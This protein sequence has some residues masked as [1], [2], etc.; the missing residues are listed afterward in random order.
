VLQRLSVIGIFMILIYTPYRKNECPDVLKPLSKKI[1]GKFKGL[2]IA[3]VS[4]GSL[5]HV[6][7]PGHGK[8]GPTRPE[9]GPARRAKTCSRAGLGQENL[10]R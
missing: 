4:I 1:D 6:S 2:P 5:L 10:A 3:I 9:N 8:P 7:K